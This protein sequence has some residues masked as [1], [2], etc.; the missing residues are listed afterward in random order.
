MNPRLL[1]A[2]LLIASLALSGC[3]RFAE[4]RTVIWAKMG[5]PARIVDDRLIEVLVPTSD[6]GWEPGF[7][8]LSGMVALDEPTLEL[9]QKNDHGR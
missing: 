2:L 9:Y 4:T 8:N 5:T 6:G 7:A 3:F 1:L